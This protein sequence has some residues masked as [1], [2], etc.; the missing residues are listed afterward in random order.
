MEKKIK[1][2]VN[3]EYYYEKLPNGLEVYFV[4]NNHL[5]SFYITFT[6]KF[7]SSVKEFKRKGE[8]EYHQVP[9]GIAHFLE[10]QMFTMEDGTS[11]ALQFDKLGSSANAYT[12]YDVTCYEVFGTRYFKEN[13][14]LLINYVQD[15]H[16]TKK[17]VTKEIGIITE[18]IKSYVN[19]P[20]HE[21]NIGIN[22][23]IFSKYNEKEKVTG[24]EKDI[25][26]I[27]K[28]SLKLC[29]DYF[30]HP[31]NMF[32]IIS[33]NFN[34]HEAL[35][36]IKENQSKKKFSKYQPV[37]IKKYKEPNEVNCKYAEKE[38]NVEIPKINI[39]YKINKKVFKSL[40]IHEIELRCYLLLII[41]SSL[42]STSEF[43]QSLLENNLILSW[44]P[45][46]RIVNDFAV[47]GVT[48]K[49]NYTNEVLELV[50]KRFKN[51][52][53]TENEFNRKVKLL[54]SSYVVSFDNIESTNIEIQD[55]LINNGS[56]V[57][58]YYEIVKSLTYSE[59]LKVMN[60]I[61]KNLNN[62]VI[63]KII[64]FM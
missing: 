34:I 4:P 49:T 5:K 21:L 43:Y 56:L 54:L 23:L 14:E 24:E 28:E 19:N 3:E 11:A 25:T 59:V 38:M 46:S 13:L 20:G 44:S 37:I 32:I 7:G 55:D 1:S 8:K 2:I 41:K 57:D 9:N 62:E 53:I 15:P 6:T 22:K 42:S 33:G 18:E 47:I 30:Y 17:G 61:E 58:N 29:Y 64:P 63:Y 48:I 27:T 31:Q 52:S 10:H 12:S 50:R 26:K 51:L 45:Y 60:I 16:F 39:C 36:I 40:K 35:S